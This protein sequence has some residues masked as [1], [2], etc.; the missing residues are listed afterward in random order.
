M[1]F[2]EYR[3]DNKGQIVQ[4][5][6]L[7][8]GYL[9]TEGFVSAPLYFH[10]LYQGDSRF[11][12]LGEELIAK[13]RTEVV[14]FAQKAT[15]R[16]RELFTVRGGQQFALAQGIAWI[17]PADGQ[18]VWM[19]K[20]TASPALEIGLESQITQ[21]NFGEVRFKG[22]TAALWLPRQVKV[23]TKLSG[24]VYRNTHFYS[25]FKQFSV[26]TEEKLDPV[27]R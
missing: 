5:K 26:Q 20:E 4:R 1:G 18:I 15:A 7:E 19:L 2:K 22:D 13:R 8:S 11:R 16:A 10:P 3:T 12:Y 21:L 25:D 23:E 24:V 27:S 9:I 14:A 6:G 17:D